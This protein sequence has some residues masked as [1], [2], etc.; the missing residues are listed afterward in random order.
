MK[1]FKF[2]LQRVIDVRKTK[3]NECQRE[4]SLSKEELKR[5]E[6]ELE[7]EMAESS[8]SEK[9]LRKALKQ[10]INAGGL[11]ALHDY[12][13]WTNKKVQLQSDRTEVQRLEVNLKRKTLIQASK[14]KKVLERLKEKRFAEHQDQQKKED[15]AFMDEL[16]SR[17]INGKYSRSKSN[18]NTEE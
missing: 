16:G 12:T 14:E 10:K 9:K 2:R 18:T 17:R 7:Q 4:L 5:H 6:E 1:K 11:A 15:Q 3:E 8:E 13:T